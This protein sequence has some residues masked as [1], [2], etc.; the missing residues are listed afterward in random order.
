MPKPADSER[1]IRGMPDDEQFKHLEN[2]T[3]RS[4]EHFVETMVAARQNAREAEAAERKVRRDRLRETTVTVVRQAVPDFIG[5]VAGGIVLGFLALI[6]G[7]LDDVGVWTW[8]A[9]GVP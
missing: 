9:V 7:V 5:T 6:T 3:F 1:I 4:E 8:I 2:V